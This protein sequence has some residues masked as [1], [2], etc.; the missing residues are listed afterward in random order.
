MM[1]WTKLY[2]FGVILLLSACEKIALLSTPQKQP[3]PSNNALATKAELDFWTIFHHGQYNDISKA[4]YELTA[5]YLQNPN[6][7]KLAAHLGFLHLWKITEYQRSHHKNPMITNEIILA[8]QF[9][10]DAVKLDPKN[11]IYQGFLGDS[12]L[13]QGTIFKDK[14][15]EV[16]GYFRLK[17][18]IAAW[19]EFNYFTAG[20]PM[21]NLPASSDHFKEGLE[22]QWLT[23]DYCAG[24]TI[25]RQNPDYRTV[26]SHETTHGRKR[27]CWNSWIAPY[28]FEGFFMNMGD[29]L[30]KSGDWKKAIII[31]NNAKIAKNYSTWPYREELEHKIKNAQTNVKSYQ[32]TSQTPDKTIMFNSGY[33]CMACHSN[34]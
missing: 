6:D 30:V 16:R 33:G 1:N 34:G 13:I 4:T 10:S 15:E 28:N 25:N 11:P 2:L 24:K 20:Y 9:F 19:P 7:P 17:K 5:A 22:W 27:A 12:Q 31:Y 26:M 23:L 21:S 18:A 32:L 8:K 29:M 14:K 3:I